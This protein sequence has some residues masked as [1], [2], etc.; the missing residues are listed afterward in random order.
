MPN[1]ATLLKTM[2][3]GKAN[4]PVICKRRM[5]FVDKTQ[6]IEALG[7]C[8]SDYPFIVR[9]RRFGKS[10][11]VSMLAAYYD[12]AASSQFEETFADTYIGSHKTA[13]ASSFRVLHFD[14]S[15]L[16]SSSNI[17]ADFQ[18]RVRDSLVEYFSKYPH[19]HQSEILDRPF[20]TAASLISSFFALL[21]VEYY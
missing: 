2:P 4:F 6:F 15:G 3:C 5:A 16:T 11:T 14:F 21:A 8:G 1:N 19:P 20:N 13:L 17:A 18:N 12:E 7:N 10:L 9:P